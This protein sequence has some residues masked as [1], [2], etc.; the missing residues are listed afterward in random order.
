ML[1]RLLFREEYIAPRIS[2][3]FGDEGWTGPGSLALITVD[4][5]SDET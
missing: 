1:G 5:F 2:Y 3:S 4:A